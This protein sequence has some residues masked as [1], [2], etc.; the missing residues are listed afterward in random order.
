VAR[1]RDEAIGKVADAGVMQPTVTVVGAELWSTPISVTRSCGTAPPEPL[2]GS[3]MSAL[4]S[5]VPEELSVQRRLRPS[6][7]IVPERLRTALTTYDPVGRSSE[8]PLVANTSLAP[9]PLP[10][11]PGAPG[12][13][14]QTS[15]TP[16][17]AVS[18][19]PPFAQAEAGAGADVTLT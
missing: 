5:V 12:A 13:P 16:F 9:S 8:V 6:C 18:S 4:S 1:I 14:L 15:P 17:T 19:T 11:L 3:S 7:P 2:P 10:S